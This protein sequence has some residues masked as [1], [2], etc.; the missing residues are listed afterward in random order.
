MIPDAGTV[1]APVITH[2]GFLGSTRE[3]G[4]RV[5]LVGIFFGLPQTGHFI[6][7]VDPFPFLNRSGCIADNIVIF[8]DGF[9]GLEIL[10]R[11]LVS[12]GNI[13]KKYD[14]LSIHN[15]GFSFFQVCGRQCH[16]VLRI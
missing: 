4:Y 13:I 2:E 5:K 14:G 8:A 9:P 1:L 10:Q 7:L 11:N 15:N 12:I 16:R 3:N 6:V